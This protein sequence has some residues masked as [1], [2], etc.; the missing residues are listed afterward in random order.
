MTKYLFFSTIN[1]K[2]KKTKATEYENIRQNGLIAI[3]LDDED[4]LLGVHPTCGE[5]SVLL[6]SKGGKS[7]L[8]KEDDVR[9][10][11]RATQGVKG[12]TLKKDD[13]LIGMEIITA[14]EEDADAADY[15][16]LV[17]SENG[18]GKRTKLSEYSHQGRGG[19]GVYTAK[20]SSKTG[21]L[22]AA[23]IIRN[24]VEDEDGEEVQE[25]DLLVVSQQGQVIRLPLDDVPHLG[26]HTQGVRIIKLSKD[27]KVSAIALL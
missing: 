1:G 18:Y 16:V 27:D 26:R 6:I 2:V 4:Q 22:A 21:D 8:F 24:G 13:R 15:D 12:I 25:K 3:S 14:E 17:I 7:I 9:D 10:T 19:Q 5:D 11:G 20:L 23:R